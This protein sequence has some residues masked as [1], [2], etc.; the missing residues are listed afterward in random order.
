MALISAVLL[1]AARNASADVTVTGSVLPGN[2]G[3]PWAPASTL[4]VGGWLIPPPPE[5]SPGEVIV[6]NRGT[7]ITPG[8]IIAANH[9]FHGT[10]TVD[11]YGSRWINHGTIKLADGGFSS[12]LLVIHQG[13][14]VSTDDIVVGARGIHACGR[15][16]VEGY[17]ATLT[18]TGTTT[19]GGSDWTNVV[20]LKDGGSIFSNNVSLATP[21]DGSVQALLTG[22]GTRWVS[23]GQFIVGRNSQAEVEIAYKAKLST[24]NAQITGIRDS[25]RRAKVHVSGWDATWTNQGILRIGSVISGVLYPGVGELSVG[26]EGTL[27]TEGVE[28]SS[29]GGAAF[30]HVDGLHAS[31]HDQGDVSILDFSPQAPALVIDNGG[32]VRIDGLLSL[33]RQQVRPRASSVVA[34]LVNGDLT[35]GAIEALDGTLAF[36]GGRLNTASFIGD[37]ENTQAGML[38]V[39]GDEVESP[40]TWII[41]DYTQGYSATLRLTVAASSAMPLLDVGGSVSLDGQLQVRAAAGVA[42]FQAGDTVTLLG[43]SGGL[44]GSFAQV[45]IDLPLAP[46]L[47]WDASELYTTGQ[48][49]AVP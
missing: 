34:R 25:R 12:G 7:L 28:I 29:D 37:L 15:L 32:Q 40:S 21:G 19:I 6:S 30:I 10:V 47:T 13:A 24:V 46:G 31:W 39:G 42:P 8:A 45:S 9:D 43:W 2:P 22:Y 41:G 35:A 49:H 17:D 16:L 11:G 26:A 23:T 36:A 14:R 1:S 20:E 48:I 3:D 38:V 44:T 18:S 27:E 33:D 4:L 5:N